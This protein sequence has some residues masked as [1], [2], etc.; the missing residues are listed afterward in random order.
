MLVFLKVTDYNKI[1]RKDKSARR[2][3]VAMTERKHA[4]KPYPL[5][6]HPEDGAIRFAYASGKKDCGIILY[7]RESGKKLHKIPFCRE[8]RMG[9]V[10]C[11]YLEL[12]PKQIGYQFYEEERIVPDL[13]ARGF[14][15]KPAY[16]KIRKNGNRIAVF[17]GANFDWEQDEHPMLSYCESVCYCMHVRGFTMH[18]S[19]KVAHRGTFAGIAEKLDYLQEIG[20]T[21]VEMQP[22][23]EFDETPEEVIPKTSADMAA[24]AGENGGEFPGYLVL[25]YWGYREGFYYA[26]KASYAPPKGS[27]CDGCPYWRLLCG[28]RRCGDGIQ[29]TGEGIP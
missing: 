21:T 15:S 28:R 12:D 9:N 3:S 4:I 13:H 19:S 2:W 18:A 29:T 7:D 5:G 25:N 26:P 6:A 16:G 27:R 22:V 20:I 10:Y 1:V 17:P 14:L 24:T 23:Y 11:K 8:E